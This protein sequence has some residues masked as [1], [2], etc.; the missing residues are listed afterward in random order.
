MAILFALLTAASYGIADFAGGLAARRAHVLSV[1]AVSYPVGTVALGGSAALFG[2][3]LPARTVLLSAV[4]GLI[5]LVGVGLLYGALAIAPMNIVSPITGVLSAAVPVVAGVAFGER[6]SLLAWGGIALGL[7][8][9]ILVSRQ[10]DDHP[11]GPIGA[12]PIVLAVGA[13][14]GFG[15]FFV[16]LA[17]TAHTSGL[18]PVAIARVSAAVVIVAVALAFGKVGRMARDAFRLACAAAL[19]DAG[20]NVSFLIASR[21]G[22]LSLVAVITALYPAG[23]VLLA[24]VVLKERLVVIQKLGLAMGAV[25]VV[26][27]T[28]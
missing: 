23:T 11:H 4:G 18:W 21:H 24:T 22:L 13:G 2:G 25:S 15:G 20:A 10:P 27:V 1:L 19:L 28:R 16:C 14:L 9:V 3:D 26:L 7:L 17:R 6:P 12:R 5:G 8:A